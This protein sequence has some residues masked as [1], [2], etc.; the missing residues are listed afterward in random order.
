MRIPIFNDLTELGE[1]K[2]KEKQWDYHVEIREVGRGSID[3]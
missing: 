3:M 2:Q 1:M